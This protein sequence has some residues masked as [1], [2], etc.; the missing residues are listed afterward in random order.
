MLEFI[1]FQQVKEVNNGLGKVK[2]NLKKIFKLA[3]QRDLFRL[4]H[5]LDSNII[6]GVVK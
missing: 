1:M 6:D 5:I 3:E 4:K 2:D